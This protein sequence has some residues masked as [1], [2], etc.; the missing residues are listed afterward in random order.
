MVFF[1]PPTSSKK[2]LE[3][4]LKEVGNDLHNFSSAI[5]DLLTVLDKVENLLMWSKDH[6]NQ[7]MIHF[8]P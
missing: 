6:P 5:D 3:D 7:C 2:H 8:Y 1:K 4:Q